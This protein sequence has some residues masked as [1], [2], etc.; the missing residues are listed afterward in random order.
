M[1][2]SSYY[3]YAEP[4]RIGITVGNPRG[5]RGGFPSYKNLAPSWDMVRG[6]LQPEEYERQYAMIL[7]AL[8]PA[9]VWQELHDLVS[10]HEPIL[11]CFERPP[12]TPTNWCHRR[13]VADWFLKTLGHEVPELG[14]GLVPKRGL[15]N[16]Q[17]SFF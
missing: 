11:M 4:G 8:D 12:F 2:T 13:L 3:G 15:P 17:R 16:P 10:T 7:E 1:Q 5:V 9:A 14:H 6:K